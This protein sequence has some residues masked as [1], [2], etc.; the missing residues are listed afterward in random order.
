[1]RALQQKPDPLY[2]LTV[3]PTPSIGLLAGPI[4][5]LD[6]ETPSWRAIKSYFDKDATR[7]RGR[8]KTIIVD[9]PA[10]QLKLSKQYSKCKP[11]C[12]YVI[13]PH[14]SFTYTDTEYGFRRMLLKVSQLQARIA[15]M[16]RLG[17]TFWLRNVSTIMYNH[18]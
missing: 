13:T 6:Q 8:P 17:S 18:V 11:K 2:S 3:L 5:R 10:A 12:V 9:T 14:S 16:H 15:T 1:M 4:L 7:V